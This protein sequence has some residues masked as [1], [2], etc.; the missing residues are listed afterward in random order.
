MVDI[1]DG[2]TNATMGLEVLSKNMERVPNLDSLV[3]RR[4]CE[5]GKW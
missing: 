3:G 2:K 4:A 5:L 1:S